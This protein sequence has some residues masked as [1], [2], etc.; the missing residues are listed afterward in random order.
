[1]AVAKFLLARLVVISKTRINEHFNNFRIQKCDLNFRSNVCS[2]LRRHIQFHYLYNMYY[3]RILLEGLGQKPPRRRLRGNDRWKWKS[4]VCR[5]SFVFEWHSTGV[6]LR[7]RNGAF[8][9][10]WHR[11]DY[12]GQ[13]Q[14]RYKFIIFDV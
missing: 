10:R 2:S 4:S 7:G 6:S 14:G 12:Q 5:T 11:K 8:S 13:C 9:F 1:M 3:C